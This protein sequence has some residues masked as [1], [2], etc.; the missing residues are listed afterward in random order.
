MIFRALLADSAESEQV[1]MLE[2]ELPLSPASL[3]GTSHSVFI[4]IEGWDGVLLLSVVVVLSVTTINGS[5]MRL[6]PELEV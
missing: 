1:G 4:E 5:V 2:V 3:S 6:S